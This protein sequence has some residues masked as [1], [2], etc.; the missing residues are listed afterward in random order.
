MTNLDP[1]H[2]SQSMAPDLSDDDRQRY[3]L[4]EFEKIL[5]MLDGA[6]DCKWIYQ[7]L[8]NLSFLHRRVTGSLPPAANE[9]EHWINVLIDID[10]LRLNRWNFMKDILKI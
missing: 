9:W 8:L 6:E 10:A 3:L 2:A 1:D 7:A 5:E 4:D